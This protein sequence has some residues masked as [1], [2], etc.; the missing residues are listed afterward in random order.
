MNKKE[1]EKTFWMLFDGSAGKDYESACLHEAGHMTYLDV[2]LPDS[3]RWFEKHGNIYQTHCDADITVQQSVLWSL[4]GDV[5]CLYERRVPNI[6]ELM[7][8][9]ARKYDRR[10]SSDFEKIRKSLKCSWNESK[11]QFLDLP[12]FNEKKFD[13]GY[14]NFFDTVVKDHTNV[15]LDL[16]NAN[17]VQLIHNFELAIMFFD[18]GRY[19]SDIAKV[20]E[21]GNKLDIAKMFEGTYDKKQVSEMRKFLSNEKLIYQTLAKTYKK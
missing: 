13:K 3:R 5:A 14:D 11:K 1:I 10:K 7:A 16:F 15:L 19:H 6:P 20:L 2:A 9:F 17:E 4:A 12:N 8:L 21:S 18:S